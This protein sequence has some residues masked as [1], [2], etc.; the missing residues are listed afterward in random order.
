MFINPRLL[1]IK[2]LKCLLCCYLL[3]SLDWIKCIQFSSLDTNS[4]LF[5]SEIWICHE[6]SVL[7]GEHLVSSLPRLTL[8]LAPSI[9]LQLFFPSKEKYPHVWCS[10]NHVSSLE[11]YFQDNV[12]FLPIGY[13][14]FWKTKNK[15]IGRSKSRKLNRR[16]RVQF[17]NFHL[18]RNRYERFWR[19]ASHVMEKTSNSS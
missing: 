4:Q 16:C 9:F 15:V 6:Y 13:T 12:Q 7:E 19:A 2:R 17:L 8:C 14:G 3:N 18:L 11:W 5:L 1:H 10:D